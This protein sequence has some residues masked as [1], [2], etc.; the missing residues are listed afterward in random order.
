[1]QECHAAGFDWFALNIGDGHT[2]ED[3]RIVI[4]RA[5]ALNVVVM[6]WKRC[7][8]LTECWELLDRADMVSFH[9][10]L[11]IEDEFKD[12]LEPAQ[13]AKLIID[14]PDLKVGISTVAWLFND[15]DFSPLKSYP[16]LLQIFPTD[17]GWDPDELEQRQADC[18]THARDKG[19]TYV[20]ATLQTYGGAKP[21]WYGYHKGTR[22]LYT[23]DDA[24]A[25]NWEAWK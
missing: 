20:G 2:W 21:E 11:N 16:A 4:D 23:G 5:R 8:T 9:A 19:F 22:S 12:V 1:M 24:G 6:P 13:V 25:G 10:I 7:R 14:F 15:V 18:V 17:N 3:W